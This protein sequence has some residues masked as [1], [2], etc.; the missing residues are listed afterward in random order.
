MLGY[1]TSNVNNNNNNN[2]APHLLL[3]NG[4]VANSTNSNLN[5]NHV[6]MSNMTNINTANMTSTTISKN[7]L[8][9][10]A[11]K[12][13]QRI[14]EESSQTGDLILT[15]KNLNEFPSKLANNFDLSDTITA[16]KCVFKKEKE[17]NFTLKKN[18]LFLKR[19]VQKSFN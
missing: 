11:I 18:I 6:N 1:T 19:L 7:L 4:H 13:I 15:N 17:F 10:T 3:A 8:N 5:L 16:G 9:N 2:S 14:L 12:M